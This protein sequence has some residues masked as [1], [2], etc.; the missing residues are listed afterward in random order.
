[1]GIYYKLLKLGIAIASSNT[2]LITSYIRR[3]PIKVNLNHTAVLLD[4]VIFDSRPYQ[5]ECRL[6]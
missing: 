6:V 4:Y 3:D 1:M 5:C 2:I